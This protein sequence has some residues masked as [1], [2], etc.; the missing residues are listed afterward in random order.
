MKIER[1]NSFCSIF[2]YTFIVKILAISDNV[3]P[4]MESSDYLR[5][6]Y[7]E[8]DLVISCGDMAPP[9]IEF[10][11]SVLNVPLFFVR[12]N[13]D[14]NYGPGFPGGEDL[15]RH[16]IKYRDLWFAGLEGSIQYNGGAAQY[17]DLSMLHM[18]LAMSAGMLRRR[19]QRGTGVDVLVTHSP[20]RGIHDMTDQTHRGFRA[21]NLAI[22][23]YRPRYL[24][25]GHIDTWDR[26]KTIETHIGNTIVLNINPVKLF[27]VDPLTKK[28]R[29]H[30]S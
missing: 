10:V 8:V 11:A 25:H 21:L 24:I 30:G 5:R 13:H 28:G 3:L 6:T 15:H 18:T 26:R 17:S 12:G 7:A 1:L 27:T 20:P 9:Y 2:W 16:A 19:I 29:P 4:Q 14:T 23:W 22:R